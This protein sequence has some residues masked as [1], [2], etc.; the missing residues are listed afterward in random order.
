MPSQYE[1][2]YC[3]L[4]KDIIVH[5][6]VKPGRNGNTISTF[7]KTLIVYD[8]ARDFPLLF[9]RKQY[10]MGVLGEFAAFIRGPKHIRDFEFFGCNYW[11][12]WA[13]EDGSINVDYGNAWIDYN[14]INQLSNTINN[15]IVDPY[16]RRHI[17]DG[18]RPDRIDTLDLPS[19]HFLY[20]WNVTFNKELEMI[21]YQRSVDT[22]I[23][24][25]SDVILAAI[26]NIL[27]AQ[28]A[29]LKPGKITFML[30]DCHIYEEHLPNAKLYLDRAR[31]V[32][33]VKVPYRIARDGNLLTHMHERDYLFRP[34]DVELEQYEPREP[35]NFLLKA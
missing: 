8:I 32:P 27:M 16:S 3:R 2:D 10:P 30:G 12:K 15:L 24:L 13:K 17:I 26:F 5:G 28:A 6:E 1:S 4:I 29:C 21:W 25:P 7:G 31:E 19:C 9:G 18:W 11:K 35:I 20:Q 22:M 34:S 14:G 23:G 33:L